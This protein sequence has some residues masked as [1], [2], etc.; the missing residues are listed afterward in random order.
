MMTVII[1]SERGMLF[2]MVRKGLGLTCGMDRRLVMRA[3]TMEMVMLD[4]L[5]RSRTIERRRERHHEVS[6]VLRSSNLFIR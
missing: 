3:V 4:M 6:L 5:M 1:R 2:L